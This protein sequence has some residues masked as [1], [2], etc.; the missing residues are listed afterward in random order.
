MTSGPLSSFTDVSQALCPQTWPQEQCR[1]RG[2]LRRHAHLAAAATIIPI[3]S[4]S[5]LDRDAG[6]VGGMSA[7]EACISSCPDAIA[8]FPASCSAGHP[9]RRC[10]QTYQCLSAD[11]T[12]VNLS[13]ESKNHGEHQYRQR[14]HA[15]ACESDPVDGPRL[16]HAASVMLADLNPFDADQE[17]S[18]LTALFTRRSVW[19]LKIARANYISRSASRS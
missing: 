13:L 10:E 5:T 18:G 12:F 11:D 16:L 6:R 17:T 2:E 9:E 19:S 1:H 7:S 14:Q 3:H 15:V 8:A 4:G